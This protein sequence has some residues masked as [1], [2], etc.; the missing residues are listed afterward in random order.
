MV[1]LNS[2]TLNVIKGNL[3]ALKEATDFT[4]YQHYY[5]PQKGAAHPKDVIELDEPQAEKGPGY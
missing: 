4:K 5:L 2:N 1:N 3:Q